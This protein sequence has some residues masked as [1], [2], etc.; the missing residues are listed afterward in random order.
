M[1][2]SKFYDY[3]GVHLKKKKRKPILFILNIGPKMWDLPKL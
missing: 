1:K 2:I 3:E